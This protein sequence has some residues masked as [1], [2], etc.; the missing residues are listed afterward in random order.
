MKI[1]ISL[2]PHLIDFF[3]ILLRYPYSTVQVPTN[4]YQS[5]CKA[6]FLWGVSFARAQTPDSSAS[7]HSWPAASK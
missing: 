1:C 5:N 6:A 7:P 2:I 4:R 3:L